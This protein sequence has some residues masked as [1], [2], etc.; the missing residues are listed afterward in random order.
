VGLRRKEGE[1]GGVLTAEGAGE[2]G[3]R[4]AADVCDAVA[5]EDEVQEG[6]GELEDAEGEELGGEW[7]VGSAG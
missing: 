7:H 2:G 5:E 1:R 6:E 4:P 3:V